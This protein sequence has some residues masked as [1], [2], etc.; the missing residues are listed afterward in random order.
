[1]YNGRAHIKHDGTGKGVGEMKKLAAGSL[2]TARLALC[3][4]LAG[5]V[6][7]CVCLVSSDMP[8]FWGHRRAAYGFVYSLFYYVCF[9]HPK[10]EKK[11]ILSL[12]DMD[13]RFVD[14]YNDS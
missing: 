12:Q 7:V 14:W 4:S 5:Y 6:F 10:Q 8:P 3:G 9:K 1:M 2:P 11:K 13:T